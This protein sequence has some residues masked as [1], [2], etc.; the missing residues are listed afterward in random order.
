MKSETKE[1][2][3]S[4]FSAEGITSEIPCEQALELC[5]THHIDPFD[6]GKYCDT[7]QIKMKHCL[8]GCFK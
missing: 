4:I 7:H 6:M 2:I 3:S 8:F 5:K 1:K